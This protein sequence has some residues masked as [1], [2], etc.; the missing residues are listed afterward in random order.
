MLHDMNSK[1]TLKTKVDMSVGCPTPKEKTMIKRCL[2]LCFPV[3][4]LLTVLLFVCFN[5]VEALQDPSKSTESGL[6]PADT[7]PQKSENA[8]IVVPSDGILRLIPEDALGVIYCPSL[9]ELESRIN[10]MVA[11]LS[12]QI[13]VP[14]VSANALVKVFGTEF[15]SLADFEEIGLDLN[16]D[17]A[18]F[19]TS[20]QPLHLFA[21]AHLTDS[22]AMK[23]VVEA[24]GNT[25][26]QYKGV[27]YW[28][29]SEGNQSF[30]ILG[31]M[32]VFSTP[33]GICEKVIDTYSGAVQTITQN[34][35]YGTFLTDIL[36]GEDQIGV[37]IDVEAILATLDR[38]LAE[39]LKSIVDTLKEGDEASKTIASFLEDISELEDIPEED[40]ASIEMLQSIS[41]RLEVEG[42]DVQ[43]KP[44]L[45]LK[46]DSE[47][48]KTLEAVSGELAFLDELPKRA[49]MNGAFQ[50][51]PQLQ[52]ELSTFWLDA[53]PQKTPEQ[54][55]QREALLKQVKDFH[56]SLADR[57]SVS[58]N[59]RG[60]LL[61]DSLFIYELRDEQRAKTYMDEVF[62]EQLNDRGGYSGKSMMHNRVEIKSYIFPEFKASLP[63]DLPEVLA[64]I[65]PTEW[66]WYYAFTEGQLLFGTGAGPEP[67]QMA[68][69]R[70]VGNEEKFSDFPSY[71][72]LVDQ[73]GTDNNIFVA[74]SPAISAKN[75]MPMVG[76]VDPNN[77]AAM[78]LFSGIFM[79]LPEDYSIGF[80]AK[81]RDGGIGAKLLI[82]LGDF[83]QFI[84]MITMMARM[85]QMQ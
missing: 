46:S 48:L 62:L 55:A 80:S 79:N 61:P 50:G 6:T 39:E 4:V 81:A 15:E 29:A 28:S 83:R 33:R 25:P 43:I 26:T 75:S 2:R 73:L 47:F 63:E 32:L 9:L 24:E 60:S 54:Q 64:N 82:K 7:P 30:A 52:A 56:E 84:E 36:E 57:W 77:A 40:I 23:Q 51:C 69:D 37:C 44:F 49:S 16:Q 41:V 68:L 20:L 18:I 72:K 27:T 13:E 67:L 5:V 85:G 66:R 34:P 3:L 59:F 70:K 12:P 10:A 31:N 42:T 74:I 22:E 1:L 19:L 17:F 58:F 8:P 71:Q 11:E 21:V 76:E 65:M 45:K 53:F 14:D 35:N 38:P 78:Q